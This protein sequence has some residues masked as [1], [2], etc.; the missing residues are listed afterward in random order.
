MKDWKTINSSRNGLWK[1]LHS[2][3]WQYICY[4]SFFLNLSNTLSKNLD[5][6]YYIGLAL[7][8]MNEMEQQCATTTT[9]LQFKQ[10]Q[11]QEKFEQNV[12]RVVHWRFDRNLGIVH[13]WRHASLDHRHQA[14]GLSFKFNPFTNKKFPNKKYTVYIHA[15]KLRNFGQILTNLFSFR[16]KRGSIFIIPKKWYLSSCMCVLDLKKLKCCL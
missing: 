14:F 11:Q 3:I 7:S 16:L 2:M 10:Q 13:K 5:K 4:N 15:Y 6:L 9:L 1:T 12:F 8:H